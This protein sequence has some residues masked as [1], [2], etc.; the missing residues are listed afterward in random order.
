MFPAYSL[1]RSHS[2]SCLIFTCVCHTY[3]LSVTLQICH[4]APSV[5]LALPLNLIHFQSLFMAV[6]FEFSSR[7]P[8]PNCYQHLHFHQHSISRSHSHLRHT[9]SNSLNC[10]HSHP[11]TETLTYT[12]SPRLVTCSFSI[13]SF[14]F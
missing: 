7:H 12:S 9:S 1:A 8:H 11:F 4:F 10:F 14:S 3:P 2:L 5:T 13:I 6:M